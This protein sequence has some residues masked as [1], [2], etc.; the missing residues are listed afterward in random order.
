LKPTTFISRA[1][2]EHNLKGIR[3]YFVV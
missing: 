2:N 1:S 3:D